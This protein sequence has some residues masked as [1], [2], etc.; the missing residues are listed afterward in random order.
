MQDL[1]EQKIQRILELSE[2][3]SR[4]LKSIRRSIIVGRI[5]HTVYWAVLIGASIGAFWFLRPYIS[6]INELFGGLKNGAGAVETINY[7]GLNSIL[8]NLGQ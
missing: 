7:E 4:I 5:I 6:Q 1:S 3:N 2:S 8:K